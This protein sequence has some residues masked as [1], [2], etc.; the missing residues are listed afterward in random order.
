LKKKGAAS[1]EKKN[2]RDKGNAHRFETCSAALG[3]ATAVW[4]YVVA[5]S[6]REAPGGPLGNCYEM[7]LAFSAKG[8]DSFQPGATPQDSCDSKP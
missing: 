2:E 3:T 6:L 8:A 5:A 7:P 4:S 1:G